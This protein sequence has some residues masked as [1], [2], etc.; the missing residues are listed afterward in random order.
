MSIII[1][2]NVVKIKRPGQ[3]SFSPK[4]ASSVIS[5]SA[6]VIPDTKDVEDCD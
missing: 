4:D 2:A 6:D 3:T 5:N 1:D